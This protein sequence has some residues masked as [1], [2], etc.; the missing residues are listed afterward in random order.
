LPIRKRLIKSILL[1]FISLPAQIPSGGGSSSS[2]NSW[3][4]PPFQSPPEEGKSPSHPQ[5]RDSNQKDYSFQLSLAVHKTKKF[6]LRI[7]NIIRLRFQLRLRI[8]IC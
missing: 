4:S 7:W 2:S 1:N 3:Q 5:F 8:P 6:I